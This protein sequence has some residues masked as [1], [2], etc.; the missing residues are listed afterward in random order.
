MKIDNICTRKSELTARESD[1]RFT[2]ESGLGA[3]NPP[4]PFRAKLGSHRSYSITSS[5][6]A[7]SVGQKAPF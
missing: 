1:F 5:A 6:R 3:D 7:S 4:C 2:P